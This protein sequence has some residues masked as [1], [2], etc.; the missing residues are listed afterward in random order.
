MAESDLSIPM[1]FTVRWN[2]RDDSFVSNRVKQLSVLLDSTVLG[3]SEMTKVQEITS[4]SVNV[5]FT[6]GKKQKLTVVEKRNGCR[7]KRHTV[8]LDKIV[9][10]NTKRYIVYNCETGARLSE[11]LM[12][13]VHSPIIYYSFGVHE[14]THTLCGKGGCCHVKIS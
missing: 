3:T 5:V 2:G 4:I 10:V 13:Q 9:R 1:I 11:K 6:P 12:D 14:N 8:E 7:T